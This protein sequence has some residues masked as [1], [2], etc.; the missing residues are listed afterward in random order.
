MACFVGRMLPR[1][2]ALGNHEESHY[3]LWGRWADCGAAFHS[4][5]HRKSDESNV[6][7]G[8]LFT[9]WFL[10]LGLHHVK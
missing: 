7:L 2:G 3:L 1:N 6:V 10:K 5:R 8:A 9:G 4:K